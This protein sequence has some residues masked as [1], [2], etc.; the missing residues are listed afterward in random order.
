VEH[1]VRLK[2]PSWLIVSALI[3]GGCFFSTCGYGFD[4]EGKL[5]QHVFRLSNTMQPRNATYQEGLDE[6]SEYIRGSLD[7]MGVSW[8]KQDYLVDNRNVHNIICYYGD[9][10]LPR[11]VIGA[12]YDVCMDLP[13][14]DDN[15][16]GVAGLLE[17]A[18][19]FHQE[20][21]SLKHCIEMVFYTLEEPPYF[22]TTNMGSYVHAKD[23]FD[24]K[25]KVAAMICLEMIGYYSDEKG[26]QHYPANIMKLW[27]PNRGNF[28]A[29]VGKKGMKDLAKVFCKGIRKHSDLP[30]EMLI[31]PPSI[32]GVDFSDH[33]N[34][35][36]FG[37]SAV[38]IT[39]SA[40]MRNRNYHR[41]TDT[42]DTLDYK[43]MA[44][45]VEGLFRTIKA[46][47]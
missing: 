38:M 36:L 29:I 9:T 17:L 35:W 16:S 37:F 22:R 26:S 45:L 27:Y 34:Y 42:W 41:P 8:R 13:G 32:A 10:T 1:R 44:E 12:H 6:A 39:D 21:P 47:Y 4:L 43:K 24:R 31:A 33:L 11:L 20:K 2:S 5:R 46:N 40:F 15:A 3:L 14:A 7:S 28:I 30:A 19:K 23:L 18:R 25:V